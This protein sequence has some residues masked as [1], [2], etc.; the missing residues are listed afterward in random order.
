MTPYSEPGEL[1]SLEF[2]EDDL[3][4]LVRT[5]SGEA[6]NQT[7]AAQTGV[8]WVVRWRC[9][10]L[11]AT[12]GATIKLVCLKRTQFDCWLPGPDRDRITH[13][14]PASAEYRA[15]KNIAAGVLNGLV[16]DPSRCSLYYKN[17]GT[18]PFSW[19]PEARPI[20]T[21]DK[22]E[23]YSIAPSGENL[24]TFLQ[25]RNKVNATAIL[26]A[27]LT[28]ILQA[29]PTIAAQHW[30]GNGPDGKLNNAIQIIRDVANTGVVFEQALQASAAIQNPHPDI[31]ATAAGSA[32]AKAAAQ[33]PAA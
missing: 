26:Q 29:G 21:L 20:I 3:D 31:A 2:N 14:S 11:P 15:L 16:P 24:L 19:A 6:S 30:N 1:P 27:A 9:Q 32:T 33:S 22:L 7:V 25:R 4:V 5:L 13:L 12:F 8:A 23:F 28:A 18:S 17:V 10:L